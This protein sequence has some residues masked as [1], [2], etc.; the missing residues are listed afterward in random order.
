MLKIGFAPGHRSLQYKAEHL[1][2]SSFLLLQT[3]A[4][5]ICDYGREHQKTRT[6]PLNAMT[7]KAFYSILFLQSVPQST[8]TISTSSKSRAMNTSL[9]SYL[10]HL[11]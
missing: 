3:E 5:L 11:R 6:I 8:L 7:I 2:W 9:K 4:A 1:G 10:S